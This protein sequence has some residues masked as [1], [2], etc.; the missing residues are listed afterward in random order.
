MYALSD[1]LLPG[2]AG[3]EEWINIKKE[4]QF[5]YNDNTVIFDTER[6]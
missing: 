4:L 5:P 2:D 6:I 3:G 1:S